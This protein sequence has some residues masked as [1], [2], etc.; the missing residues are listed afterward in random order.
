MPTATSHFLLSLF[1]VAIRSLV[2]DAQAVQNCNSSSFFNVEVQVQPGAGVL[3]CDQTQ[4]TRLQKVIKSVVDNKFV[5]YYQDT[6]KLSALELVD[7]CAGAAA[8]GVLPIDSDDSTAAIYATLSDCRF[9]LV[10][11]MSYRR[12]YLEITLRRTLL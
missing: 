1:L 12:C 7:H 6:M 3:E 11:G 8:S 2:A 9:C 10:A 4:E 5:T